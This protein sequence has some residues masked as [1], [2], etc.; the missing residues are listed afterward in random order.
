VDVFAPGESIT[1]A[2]HTGGWVTMDGTSMAAPHITGLAAYLIALEGTPVEKLCA[3][4]QQLASKGR[5][6][7]TYGSANLLA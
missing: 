4:M 3:R 6:L 5:I 7:N 1:S 2:A